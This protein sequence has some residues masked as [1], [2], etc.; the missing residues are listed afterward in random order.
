MANDNSGRIE[1]VDTDLVRAAVVAASAANRPWR[2]SDN[3]IG[4][5]FCTSKK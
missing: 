2:G 1:L 3:T 4:K 5:R